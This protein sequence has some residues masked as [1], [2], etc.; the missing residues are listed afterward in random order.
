MSACVKGFGC[1]PVANVAACRLGRRPEASGEGTRES[2][3]AR[4]RLCLWGLDLWDGSGW[5]ADGLRSGVN[6]GGAHECRAGIDARKLKL[7]RSRL[8]LFHSPEDWAQFV[9]PSERAACNFA[10]SGRS[11]HHYD[12]SIRNLGCCLV[13]R[14]RGET[15]RA[16]NSMMNMRPPQHGQG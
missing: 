3:R 12:V 2:S 7:G 11:D 16:K 1:R 4:V 15:P 5:N 13:G 14:F 9:G 8:D 6:R 10:I